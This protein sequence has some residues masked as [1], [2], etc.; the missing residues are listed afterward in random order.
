MASMLYVLFFIPIFTK[1]DGIFGLYY[2]K[3]KWS[4]CKIK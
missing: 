2:T 1:G 3:Q 4:V